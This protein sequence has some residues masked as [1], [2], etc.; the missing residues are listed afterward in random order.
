[1]ALLSK[2]RCTA[3]KWC[4]A[5]FEGGFSRFFKRFVSVLVSHQSAE[6]GYSADPQTLG[7]IYY[8][9][10]TISPANPQLPHDWKT[11]LWA[12][13]QAYISW[14]VW[15]SWDGGLGVV[16]GPLQGW[17]VEPTTQGQARLVLC[18]NLCNLNGHKHVLLM[19]KKKKKAPNRWKER[20]CPTWWKETGETSKRTSVF[21]EGTSV[22]TILCGWKWPGVI[23]KKNIRQCSTWVF[24]HQTGSKSLNA[25]RLLSKDQAF[26]HR[27]SAMGA[28]GTEWK[29][30]AS[31]P[32]RH[33]DTEEHLDKRDELAPHT[34]NK[35]KEKWA[36]TTTLTGIFI[37]GAGEIHRGLQ[38]NPQHFSEPAAKTTKQLSPET[39]HTKVCL[40]HYSCTVFVFTMT[41]KRSIWPCK[42]LCTQS[43]TVQNHHDILL[44]HK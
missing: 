31:P 33:R 28:P 6:W 32:I 14:Y 19:C 26:L 12:P 29:P 11:L 2:E 8:V 37:S 36:K 43:L 42:S 10:N 40:V 16:R 18:Q 22:F 38:L 24:R 15:A 41:I 27:C 4:L 7:R 35:S 9:F 17:P 1:M 23:Y 44:W 13:V 21:N 3:C 39:R 25:H 30:R 34:A 20:Q 5:V